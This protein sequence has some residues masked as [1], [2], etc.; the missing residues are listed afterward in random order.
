MCKALSRSL[1]C[2][3]SRQ[4]SAWSALSW[5]PAVLH[6]QPGAGP[7]GLF[8]YWLMSTQLGC[9]DAWEE[10]LCRREAAYR[11]VVDGVI[12]GC[13]DPWWSALVFIVLVILDEYLL[14]VTC[15]FVL[16]SQHATASSVSSH[17]SCQVLMLSSSSF[18][19]LVVSCLHFWCWLTLCGLLLGPPP[20]CC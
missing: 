20:T 17:G 7:A 18:W 19:R 15:L 10:L 12:R 9:Y 3:Q 8:M 2:N 16:P 1:S 13:R 14:L 4:C 5:G 11:P 6:C